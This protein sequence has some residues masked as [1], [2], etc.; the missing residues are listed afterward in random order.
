[1]SMVQNKPVEIG[2]CQRIRV[3]IDWFEDAAAEVQIKARPANGFP[4]EWRCYLKRVLGLENRPPAQTI[5][6]LRW[7]RRNASLDHA[8][9]P[10]L[11]G[12][13]DPRVIKL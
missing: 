5:P 1:M 11:R 7:N 6:W 4:M 12:L 8:P 10:L 13:R 3:L 9:E 2:V